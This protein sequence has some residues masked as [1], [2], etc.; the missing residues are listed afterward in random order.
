MNSRKH[1]PSADGCRGSTLLS[2]ILLTALLGILA[3]GY[4]AMVSQ[5]ARAVRADRTRLEALA[6]AR[7][8][9]RSFCEAVRDGHS[10][11]M[12]AIWEQFEEDEAGMEEA[13]EPSRLSRRYVSHGEGE[14]ASG[15]LRA[16][17][18]LTAWPARKEASVRTLVVWEG[19]RLS[20]SADIDFDREDIVYGPD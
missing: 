15:T 19:Y 8:I 9:H 3:A 1:P 7:S 12:E 2:V 13:E 10:P 4:L 17:I 11:A 14:N 20:L 5:S 18:T 16:R 6:A